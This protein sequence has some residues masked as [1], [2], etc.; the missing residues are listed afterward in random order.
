MGIVIKEY[1]EI[2]KNSSDIIFKKADKTFEYCYILVTIH[3][4]T[5]KSKKSSLLSRRLLN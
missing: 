5:T 4:S 2:D 1:E 3:F